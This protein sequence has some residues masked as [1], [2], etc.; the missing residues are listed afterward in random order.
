MTG[1]WKESLSERTLSPAESGKRFSIVHAQ[2]G[3]MREA[4]EKGLFVSVC[5]EM[6]QRTCDILAD[7][8]DKD[9]KSR[10]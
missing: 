10:A 9:A 1:M 5:R 4:A 8:L 2:P 3:V 7:M 6:T